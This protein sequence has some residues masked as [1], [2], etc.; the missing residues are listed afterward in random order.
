VIAVTN[1]RGDV[2]L[3]VC[4]RHADGCQNSDLG[5]ATQNPLALSAI[6]LETHRGLDV[7]VR[8]SSPSPATPTVICMHTTHLPS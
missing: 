2:T 4:T 5:P 7:K 1:L 3:L 6:S 8:H